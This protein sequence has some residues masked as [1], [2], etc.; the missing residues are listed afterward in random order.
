MS[1]PGSK[2]SLFHYSFN[3]S[4]GTHTLSSKVAF[5]K[6]NRFRFHNLLVDPNQLIDEDTL[7]PIILVGYHI[8]EK[9]VTL[10]FPMFYSRLTF[11]TLIILTANILAAKYVPLLKQLSV[12]LG[13]SSIIVTHH[14]PFPL[15]R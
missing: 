9:L 6:G 1:N 14:T 15:K 3:N 8:S 7:F 13:L 2:V 11:P 5:R 12:Q 4:K 10:I